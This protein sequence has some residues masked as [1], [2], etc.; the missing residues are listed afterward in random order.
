MLQ[1]VWLEDIASVGVAPSKWYVGMTDATN[2]PTLPTIS[3][4]RT[5]NPSYK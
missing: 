5:C 1:L 2:K 4:T 3:S